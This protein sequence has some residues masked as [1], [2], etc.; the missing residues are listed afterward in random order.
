MIA[1]QNYPRGNVFSWRAC[2]LRQWN[3]L[4]T[5]NRFDSHG[6]T[7]AQMLNRLFAKRMG[8][9][10]GRSLPRRSHHDLLS[11]RFCRD[12]LC[13]NVLL[14]ESLFRPQ[15]SSALSRARDPSAPTRGANFGGLGISSADARATA[16]LWTEVY[17]TAVSPRLCCFEGK[18][19]SFLK[20]LASCG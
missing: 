12:D 2:K 16:Q 3:D 9:R 18:G 19:A 7:A 10:I 17:E 4:R 5:A 8:C 13:N 1:H 11:N 20:R 15:V 14:S 6:V